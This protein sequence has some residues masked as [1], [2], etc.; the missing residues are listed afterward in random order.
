LLAPVSVVTLV[1]SA[2]FEIGVSDT[3]ANFGIATRLVGSLITSTSTMPRM[4][5]LNAVKTFVSLIFTDI[6]MATR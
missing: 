1:D 6:G 4:K 3:N 5:F 2:I